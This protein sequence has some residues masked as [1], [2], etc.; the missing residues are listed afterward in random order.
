MKPKFAVSASRSMPDPQGLDRR[1]FLKLGAALGA[2]FLAG[3]VG[4]SAQ[5]T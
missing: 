5:E 4:A 1:S 2:G 3:P